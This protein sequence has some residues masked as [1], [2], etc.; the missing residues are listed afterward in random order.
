[1]F[2]RVE[3]VA[4]TRIQL[5]S[6]GGNDR[7]DTRLQ[8]ERDKCLFLSSPFLLS[9]TVPRYSREYRDYF[10][11][12]CPEPFESETKPTA[13]SSTFSHESGAIQTLIR[14]ALFR[15]TLCKSRF[16]VR[17]PRTPTE[18]GTG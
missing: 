8:R 15:V 6:P 17:R 10:A 2:V 14:V 3:R 18:R 9:P 11:P 13:F 16:F 5:K 12:V 1:M 7:R 4:Y